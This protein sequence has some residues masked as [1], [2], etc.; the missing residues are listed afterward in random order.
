MQQIDIDKVQDSSISREKV[1]VFLLD[2][3]RDLL[4]AQQAWSKALK[5]ERETLLTYHRGQ[6]EM[7]EL[8]IKQYE[9]LLT[10]GSGE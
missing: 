8:M 6:I 2:A 7:L 1:E 5:D 9:Y 4:R 3:K 10:M